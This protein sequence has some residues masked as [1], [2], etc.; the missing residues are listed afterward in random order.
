MVATARAVVKLGSGPGTVGPKFTLGSSRSCQGSYCSVARYRPKSAY[1]FC[2]HCRGFPPYPRT[3]KLAAAT[4]LFIAVM[5]GRPYE[6][7][8]QV[9]AP[10]DFA[11]R[12]EFGVCTTDV[13][14][15]F[16]NVFT[17]DAKSEQYPATSV[18]VVL[19]P[20]SVQEIYDA[21]VAARFFEYPAEFHVDSSSFTFPSNH[22]RLDVRSNGARHVVS[23][24]DD[25]GNS[26][27]QADRLRSFLKKMEA[28]IWERPEIQQRF[29]GIVVACA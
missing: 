5:E 9:R 4:V 12:F 1:S 10:A 23:W 22:Y 14:D 7:R 24:S 27:P 25:A 19:P 13:M 16:E 2:A 8:A 18:S 21:F 17:R 11:F 29:F 3:M 26:T 20:A 6:F 15:T 28:L